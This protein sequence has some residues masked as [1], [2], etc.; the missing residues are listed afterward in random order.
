MRRSLLPVGGFLA[1][2]LGEFSVVAAQDD[3]KEKKGFLQ[4]FKLPLRGELRKEWNLIGHDTANCVKLQNEGLRITLPAG[5]PGERPHTGLTTR[6]HVQ[7]DFEITVKYEILK[8]PDPA[9][10]GKAP[11]RLLFI[12]NMTPTDRTVFTRRVD[13][14]EGAQFSIWNKIDNKFSVHP[15]KTKTGRLRLVRNGVL[16]SFWVAEPADAKFDHLRE[17]MFGA[18]DLVDV[19]LLATTGGPKASLEVLFSDLFVRATAL[20]NVQA[21]VL[22]KPV[23]PQMPP[24]PAAEIASPQGWLPAVLVIGV[25]VIVVI[26]LTIGAVLFL[27]RPKKGTPAASNNDDKE[28]AEVRPI[29][30]AVIFFCPTCGKKLK[31]SVTLTG[32]KVKC[33]GCGN[34]V[35]VSSANVDE[36]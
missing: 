6:L 21:V 2:F 28:A 7:G 19:K 18:E 26:A 14:A 29:S 17:A 22:E 3:A 36:S 25:G 11:T 35:C 24:A 32:K 5:F 30:D 13:E 27:F 1:L 8:E 10:T 9:D 31:A 4:E 23:A 15:A 34:A 16:V 20:P 12:A 33:V